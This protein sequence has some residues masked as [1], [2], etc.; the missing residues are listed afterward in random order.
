M[1]GF[2]ES[3]RKAFSLWDGVITLEFLGKIYP[4]AV[5]LAAVIE[6]LMDIRINKKEGSGRF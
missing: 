3:L 4:D 5:N 1:N 2:L 6:K